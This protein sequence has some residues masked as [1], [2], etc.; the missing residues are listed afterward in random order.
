MNIKFTGKMRK[1]GKS[2]V[3]TIPKAFINGQLLDPEKDYDVILMEHT[4][5][6]NE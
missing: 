5:H 3:I 2:H 1:T 4:G 6:A